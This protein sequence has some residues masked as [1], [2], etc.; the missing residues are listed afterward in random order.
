VRPEKVA[1]SRHR[2]DGKNVFL[3]AIR[4]ADYFGSFIRY[5]VKIGEVTLNCVG[6]KLF[7]RGEEVYVSFN[8]EDC[9][10]SKED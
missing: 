8:P 2:P 3:G 7:G 4:E 9:F 6:S 1:V 5:G 10:L